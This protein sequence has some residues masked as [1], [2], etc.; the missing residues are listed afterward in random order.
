MSYRNR[1]ATSGLLIASAAALVFAAC[2]GLDK[3][4]L[5]PNDEGSSGTGDTSNGG[6]GV[7]GGDAGDG[8]G[9]FSGHG[10]NGSGGRAGTSNGGGSPIEA[11]AGGEAGANVNP[12]APSVVSVS[13]ADK[14]TGV[15]VAPSIA[16]TFS[17]AMDM[18]TITS[19]TV[20]IKDEAG[21]A[22]AGSLTFADTVA[23]FVPTGRLNLLGSYTVNVSTAAKD[24]SGTA[25]GAAFSSTFT[26]RDGV[27]TKAETALPTPA[28]GGAFDYI[29]VP[30]IATDGGKRAVYAWA[31]YSGTTGTTLDVYESVYN[32]LKGWTTPTKVNTNA[33]GC[34]RP[35]VSMNSS[36]SFVVGWY[37]YDATN[38]Y[39]IQARR[40]IAGVWDATS[41]RMDTATTPVPTPQEI[42]VAIT[43]KG[44]AHV[45]WSSYTYDSMTLSD[46]YGAYARHADPTGK[47]DAPL[48]YLTFPTVG[49]GLSTPSV[50]FDAAGNGFAAYTLATGTPAKTNLV[51][52]RYLSGTNKWGVSSVGAAAGDYPAYPAT[53]ATNP[54]GDATATWVQY[55]SATT[56]YDLYASHYSKAWSA[57]VL[58]STAKTFFS[59]NA[60]TVAPIVW[61]GSS[62][63][64]AWSQSGGS[65]QNAWVSE[66]KTAWGA[67]A[68]V[69]DG[70][71]STSVPALASDG[72]GNAILLWT[73]NS[74][75]ATKAP[76]YP[77]D[78]AF[79][80][81][82]GATD[83]WSDPGHASSV[84][85][86]YRNPTL[87]ILGDGVGVAA[88]QSV[89]R[90][91]KSEIVIGY[92]Q[93]V[94]Q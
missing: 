49:S 67:P 16:V 33:S 79:S 23:S 12:N 65:S 52:M 21:A 75:A 92:S 3:V 35:V 7:I 20:Q 84:F 54:A 44:D 80:R 28:G 64:A 11:G 71:H 43:E 45:L 1:T 38:S 4:K 31:Q 32:E 30:S 57:P 66:Y 36:G 89:T 46:S 62:F 88:W 5:I 61:T 18:S 55:T 83:K 48:F 87:A 58:I 59:S 93:N 14:T 53:V 27:W 13:P 69:S 60:K 51:M 72:R 24:T 90:P 76:V 70:N 68:I 74:D 26:V 50:S 8:N 40:N 10:N 22:V 94:L 47:W 19:D 77:T 85:A 37:E 41:T 34:S 78:V 56:T 73:Q 6:N 82:T 63:I 91:G 17:A 15:E 86:G 42:S 9:S 25:L 39:T 81:L 29:S 2:G